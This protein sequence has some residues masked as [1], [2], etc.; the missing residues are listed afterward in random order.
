MFFAEENFLMSK[1]KIKNISKSFDSMCILNDINLNVEEGEFIVLVGPSGSGKSTI[2]RIIAGLEHPTKGEIIINDRIVNNLPPKDRN[3]SMVFQNYA[4]YPHMNVYENLA[5][6][7][8]M[9]HVRKEEVEKSVSKVSEML[10]INNHLSKKPKELSGGERQRVALGRAI[11]RSPELFLMDEPLSNLDAKLRTQMRAELLK[12]H[13]TLSSTVIYVTHDQIEA[14]TM[15]TRIVVLN[16]GQ[17]QQIGTPNEIYS[18]PKNIFTATFIGNPGMNLFDIEILDNSDILIYDEKITSGITRELKELFV[19]K[20]LINKK[21][22]AGIRPEYLKIKTN[23]DDSNEI[24][25]SGNINLLEVLGNEYLA[26]V[27][28]IFKKQQYPFVIK[29]FGECNLKRNERVNI[30]FDL[31]KLYFFNPETGERIHL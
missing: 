28:S 2:L 21:I 24:N 19:K 22:K 11:I 17:I 27:S 18:N 25:I 31:E 4:L 29:V 15:G 8:K 14:L 1:L 16:K 7:L 10:G 26:H 3:I 23:I 13:K 12:L 6:P 5:F 20:N 30:S 9:Q